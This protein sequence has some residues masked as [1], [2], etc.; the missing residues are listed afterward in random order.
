VNFKLFAVHSHVRARQIF[1]HKWGAAAWGELY[2]IRRPLGLV[3][4][5]A[6][7]AGRIVAS[8]YL[9]GL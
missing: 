9:D 5:I 2:Q 4:V 6:L 3:F 7:L 1:S 8:L